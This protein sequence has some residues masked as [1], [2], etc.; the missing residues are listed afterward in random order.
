MGTTRLNLMRVKHASRLR[1][2]LEG[3]IGAYKLLAR[4]RFRVNES[5]HWN[6]ARARA[7][8]CVSHL[9]D[10]LGYDIDKVVAEWVA[11]RKVAGLKSLASE[12][13]DSCE[14]RG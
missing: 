14:H 7:D 10:E 11:A 3:M 5:D 8:K 4:V 12:V 1:Q 9:M 13:L 6:G 2:D